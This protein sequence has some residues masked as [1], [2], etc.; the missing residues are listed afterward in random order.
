MVRT[1]MKPPKRRKKTR[2]SRAAKRR[3]LENKRHRGEIKRLRK[4]PDA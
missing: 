1:A 4:P 3:R 2:P